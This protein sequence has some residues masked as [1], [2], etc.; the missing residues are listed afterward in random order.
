[1]RS[2]RLALERFDVDLAHESDHVAQ[3]A[4]SALRQVALPRAGVGPRRH[5]IQLR[6]K[7]AQVGAPGGAQSAA[8]TDVLY[9][10]VKLV[11]VQD[12]K[13][14]PVCGHVESVLWIVIAP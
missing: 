10:C 12:E 7:S 3:I 5:V 9:H 4:D 6:L 2:R 13:T 14:A 8:Q 11:P 1:M